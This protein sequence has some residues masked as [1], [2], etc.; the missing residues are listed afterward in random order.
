MAEML[1]GWLLPGERPYRALPRERW[2]ARYGHRK[3]RREDLPVGATMD[4]IPGG[5]DRLNSGRAHDVV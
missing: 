2:R 1:L 3:A 5:A 4:R